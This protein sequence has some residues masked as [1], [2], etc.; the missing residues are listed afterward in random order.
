MQK[1]FNNAKWITCSQTKK[2]AAVC[3]YKQFDFSKKIK[4]ARLVASAIG[5]YDVFVDGQK[6]DKK[7][8]KKNLTVI[9]FII[10]QSFFK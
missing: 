6:T 2:G 1:C 10:Y 9:S 5:V 8:K 7:R 3:F 4:S